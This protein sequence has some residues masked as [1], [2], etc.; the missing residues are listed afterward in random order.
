MRDA[1]FFVF[2]MIVLLLFG[3]VAFMMFRGVKPIY[4]VDLAELRGLNPVV[5]RFYKKYAI[6]TV[7]AAYIRR[8]NDLLIAQDV[9][10]IL[11]A[12]E[13]AIARRAKATA[14]EIAHMQLPQLMPMPVRPSGDDE[15]FEGEPSLRGIFAEVSRHMADV[16]DV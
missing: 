11:K 12:N 8:L 6:D 15:G 3:C 7:M 13:A 16:L 4:L 14:R 9:P 1:L 10:R 5:K 2:F